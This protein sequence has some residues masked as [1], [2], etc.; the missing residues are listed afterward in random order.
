MKLPLMACGAMAYA[1]VLPW[2]LGLVPTL[3][4][5]ALC[6]AMMYFVMSLAKPGPAVVPGVFMFVGVVA[7]VP[8]MA[9]FGA[10]LALPFAFMTPDD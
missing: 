2:S 7:Q 9:T 10:I 4:P 1:M 3:W 5:A 8:Y 6:V